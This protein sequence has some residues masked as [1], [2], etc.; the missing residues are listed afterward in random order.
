MCNGVG[1]KTS[2]TVG[3]GSIDQYAMQFHLPD[4]KKQSVTSLVKQ[5]HRFAPDV[6]P[7]PLSSP[8]NNRWLKN[9]PWFEVEFLPK[10]KQQ[11]Q[12]AL[13]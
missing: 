12:A 3:A 10:P 7:M 13:A 6:F 4:D 1:V 5:W 2:G 11:V 9:N 8:R